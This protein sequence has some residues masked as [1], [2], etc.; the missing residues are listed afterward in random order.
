M[1]PAAH[2]VFPQDTA[3]TF[4]F[5]FHATDCSHLDG[6]STFLLPEL[7]RILFSPLGQ[8]PE[9]VLI[10]T[11]LFKAL[12][13]TPSPVCKFNKHKLNSIIQAKTR[14]LLDK[15]FQ[16]NSELLSSSLAVTFQAVPY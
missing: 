14:N 15:F 10:L 6:T 7:H 13:P 5:H 4:S 3:W 1:A 9:F 11:Q 12:E 16:L 2:H 8:S